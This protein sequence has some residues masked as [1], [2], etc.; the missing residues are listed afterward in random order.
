MPAKIKNRIT[1]KTDNETQLATRQ[2][3]EITEAMPAIEKALVGGDLSALNPDQRLAY[4]RSVCDSLALNALTKPFIYVTLQG[5]LAFY[6]TKDCAEQLRNRDN[7]STKILDKGYTECRTAYFV[8]AGASRPN[9]RTD[10]SI[11]ALSSVYPEQYKDYNGKWVTHSKAGKQMT[12]EDLAALIMKCETKAKRRVTMSIC[13]LGIPQDDDLSYPDN[14]SEPRIIGEQT[15]PTKEERSEAHELVAMKEMLSGLE[16]EASEAEARGHT[17]VAKYR[18]EVADDLRR[19]IARV[20]SGDATTKDVRGPMTQETDVTKSF[21]GETRPKGGEEAKKSDGVTADNWVEIRSHIGTAAGP[22]G[23]KL[24][25]L[26]GPEVSYA[27]AHS[28]IQYFREKLQKQKGHSKDDIRV[29]EAVTFA[30]K[31]LPEK[32]SREEAENKARMEALSKK[33]DETAKK[34]GSRKSEPSLDDKTETPKEPDKPEAIDWRNVVA[35]ASIPGSQMFAGKKLRDL[36]GP[37]YI[38][39]IKHQRLDQHDITRWNKEEKQFAVAVHLA[40]DELHLFSHDHTPEKEKVKCEAAARES[41]RE[42]VQDLIIDEGT[43]IAKMKERDMISAK[44]GPIGARI[45]DLS[46]DAVWDC[47]F[48]WPDIEEFLR[49]DMNKK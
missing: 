34:P 47:L 16:K 27:T 46:L 20:E 32:K 6:A 5:K 38:S 12:G 43:F 45:A 40:Y 30:E 28:Y 17:D 15:A 21:T 3:A 33:A 10:E 37:G 39:A 48:L 26:M 25:D 23:K 1:Q 8:R 22:L 35:P 13:G 49:D 29:L 44:D 14:G 41:L 9:G 36:P 24:G 4:Y 7:V 11:A 2:S 31:L 18:Y 19:R 42:K